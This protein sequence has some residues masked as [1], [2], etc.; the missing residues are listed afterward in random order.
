MIHVADAAGELLRQQALRVHFLPGQPETFYTAR[1]PSLLDQLG[2][3]VASSGGGR[4][5]HT[6]AG[7]RL[8]LDA[9]ALD[10]WTEMHLSVHGWARQLGV[11]RRPYLARGY[12]TGWRREPIPP[13]MITHARWVRAVAWD[14]PIETPTPTQPRPE[15]IAVE[16]HRAAVDELPGLGRLLRETVAAAVAPGFEE[17]ARALGRRCWCA[18]D[19]APDDCGRCWVHRIKGML[20][21]DMADRE[22]RG[23]ACW[24][25]RT[26][27][28]DPRTGTRL[29]APTTTTIIEQDGERYR[30]PAIVAR[31]ALLRGLLVDGAEDDLW[32]YRMC[33]ACGAEGWLDYT[34]STERMSA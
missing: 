32:I 28:L 25:C 20:A 10:L 14:R 15:L 6:V 23:A 16:P 17:V 26:E 11:D 30:V 24:E 7:P 27:V 18:R 5:G 9:G 4:G 22:L 34:T 8:P 31:V 12:D 13:W 21:P 29:L 2:D 3:A 1:A 19:I 33:R